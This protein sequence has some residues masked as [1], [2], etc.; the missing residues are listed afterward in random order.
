MYWQKCDGAGESE[1]ELEKTRCE[2]LLDELLE[3]VFHFSDWRSILLQLFNVRIVFQ[4]V[5]VDLIW[6]CY[7]IM[8][9]QRNG[10]VLFVC[11]L[12]VDDRCIRLP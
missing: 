1:P 7:T 6:S 10:I 3:I 11:C 2:L 5:G 8:L 4:V 12:I 9:C